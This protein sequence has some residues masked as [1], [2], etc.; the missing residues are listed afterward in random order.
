VRISYVF[1]CVIHLFTLL[2]F[3][4]SVASA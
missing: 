2:S 3:W 1:F 4:R